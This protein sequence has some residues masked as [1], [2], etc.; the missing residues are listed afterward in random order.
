MSNG[1]RPVGPDTRLSLAKPKN[2]GKHCLPS[3]PPIPQLRKVLDEVPTYDR[4]RGRS[5]CQKPS[6]SR[7]ARSAY[8]EAPYASEVTAKY[9]VEGTWSISPGLV[10]PESR[11]FLRLKSANP[12][13]HIEIHANM[14]GDPRDI[15]ALRKGMEIS[16][17]LGN[18]A[19]MKRFA[20]RELLPGPLKGE[21]LDN[22]IRDGAMS[23]HHPSRGS[24]LTHGT[25]RLAKTVEGSR[26]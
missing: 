3:K 1:V 23:M 14:L 10:R 21:A 17:E 5:L 15:V 19:A 13:H 16:R 26:F 24:S 25:A 11:G 18:S 8:V 12:K 22:L 9:A 6:R 7:Y 4:R 2:A 20:K